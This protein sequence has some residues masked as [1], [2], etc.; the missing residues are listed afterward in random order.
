[1]TNLIEV[2]NISKT[3]NHQQV[4]R[5]VTVD[6]EQGQTHGLIGRNGSGKTLLLKAILGLVTCEEGS[7]YI[8]GK[9][10]GKDFDFPENVGM[11]IERP[12]F[13]PHENAMRNLTMLAKIRNNINRS[14][15]EA[16][17]R[18][19]GL[20]PSEKKRVSTYS[21]GMKQRLG[22]A[23]ALMENPDILVLDEPFSG[24]DQVGLDDMRALFLDLK[25]SGKTIILASHNQEDIDVLCDTVHRMEAGQISQVR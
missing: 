2:N 14:E 19:V 24:L 4:L 12:G 25:Q 16:A 20:D 13:L 5:A 3:Y 23:Q 1:M 22:L 15:I 6:F 21:L 17:I 7:I 11:I 8:D 10:V 9:Q 18:L